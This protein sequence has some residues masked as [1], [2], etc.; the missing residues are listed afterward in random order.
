MIIRNP[1]IFCFQYLRCDFVL[2]TLLRENCIESKTYVAIITRKIKPII[3]ILVLFS[4][5]FS[6]FDSVKLYIIGILSSTK[7]SIVVRI[8]SLSIK[9]PDKEINIKIRGKT[10]NRK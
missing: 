8:S 1:K 9:I 5:I 4:I 3:P 7:P 10:E 2:Y 6:I